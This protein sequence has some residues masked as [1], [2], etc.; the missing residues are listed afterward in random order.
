[1]NSTTRTLTAVVALTLASQAARA[2]NYAVLVGAGTYQMN[3]L[4]LEGPRPDTVKMAEL[5]ERKFGFRA[6]N[7]RMLLD[8]Q[9]TRSNILG[10]LDWLGSV[11]QSG[12]QVLIYYSGH[13]TSSLDPNT[14]GFGLDADT[15]A[16]VP[17]DIRISKDTNAVLSQLIVGKRDLRPR[18]LSIEA[19]Q[20][21]VLVI[22]DACFAGESVRA[23]PSSDSRGRPRF[24]SLAELTQES[25]SSRALIQQER[26]APRS[27]V[28]Y[29]YSRV[30]Y[31]AASEKNEFAR[32][33]GSAV[34]QAG[35][36]KVRTYDGQPHGAFSNVLLEM[37]SSLPPSGEPC[38]KLFGS[39]RSDVLG[40][41]RIMGL[42]PQNAVLLAP[43]TPA[44][45]SRTC[46]ASVRPPAP[47][48]I[49][50]T[51]RIQPVMPQPVTPPQPYN[52]QPYDP[53]PAPPQP[54]VDPNPINVTRP[55]IRQNLESLV[56]GGGHGVTCRPAQPSYRSGERTVLTCDAPADGYLMVLSYGDG[57]PEATLL[58]PN[59][60]QP[61]AKV[62]R[63][64][65]RIPAEGERWGVQ[66]VLPRGASRQDQIMVVLF[67][68]T[69]IDPKDLGA[70]AGIF[71]NLSQD[72][73]RALRSQSVVPAAYDA[74]M[75]IFPITQ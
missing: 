75:V 17:T 70:V 65:F 10:A 58:L 13:G 20:A 42:S 57:D 74:A 26:S 31:F 56:S 62:A 64:R 18:L 36:S 37:L 11:A 66:N 46:F 15:G 7:I 69:P 54:R 44:A 45:Q 32:D 22:F 8:D 19:K 49:D 27:I 25:V 40:Q 67:S 34:M 16:I 48:P 55:G 9:A 2:E 21:D 1:M 52:P 3:N 4:S 61:V 24:I 47:M 5:L 50:T 6:N 12:D 28:D 39:L 68:E 63:G 29:P 73:T 35:G 43:D 38:G 33:I 60:Y 41:A 14:G 71:R 30:V 51:P 53:Q 72:D 23:L 59:R